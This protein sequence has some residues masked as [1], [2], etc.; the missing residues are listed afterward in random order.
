[1]TQV[2]VFRAVLAVGIL[3]MVFTGVPP[4]DRISQKAQ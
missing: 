1:M 2:T 3:G 4:A